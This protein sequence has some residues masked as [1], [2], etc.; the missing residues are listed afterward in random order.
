MG[1]H[2]SQHPPP[3]VKSKTSN[4]MCCV[5]FHVDGMNWNQHFILKLDQMPIFFLMNAKR[6]LKVVDKKTS[7]SAHQWMICS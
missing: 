2:V 1:T 6:M 7:T 4:Y 3:E 5:S